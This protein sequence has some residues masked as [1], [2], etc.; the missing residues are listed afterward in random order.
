MRVELL[1]PAK[2]K[3]E[4]TPDAFGMTQIA[5]TSKL[6]EWFLGQTEEVQASILGLYPKDD[7]ID[8]TTAI[9]KHF[10]AAKKTRA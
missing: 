6:V 9:L 1:G 3:F 10:I 7:G 4:E 5:V 8:L 2:R